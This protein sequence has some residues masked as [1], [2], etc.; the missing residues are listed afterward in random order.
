[1]V[2]PFLLSKRW[3]RATCFL[4][5]CTLHLLSCFSL[6]SRRTL[7]TAETRLPDRRKPAMPFSGFCIGTRFRVT[8]N[9]ARWRGGAGCTHPLDFHL[10][11]K[12]TNF[13]EDIVGFLLVKRDSAAKHSCNRKPRRSVY[14]EIH[15]GSK[16]RCQ[17][18]GG[19]RSG[20]SSGTTA[21]APQHASPLPF[22]SATLCLPWVSSSHVWTVWSVF[23]C[24]A[25][26]TT[27][28]VWVAR[29]VSASVG[30]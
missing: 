19:P 27:C 29:R 6:V 2:P 28:F 14:W 4:I 24:R 23:V 5:S 11:A 30:C 1:M 25:I 21:F 18:K 22:S 12:D 16:A 20:A 17:G 26:T 8:R 7:G 15:V 3:S 9:A 13:C 10:S